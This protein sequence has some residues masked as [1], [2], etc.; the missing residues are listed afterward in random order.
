MFGCSISTD[1]VMHAIE[2]MINTN[3]KLFIWLI[4]FYSNDRR[5]LMVYF[6]ESV[7]LIRALK[8]CL[9]FSVLRC[10]NFKEKSFKL[11]IQNICSEARKLLRRRGGAKGMKLLYI[12][13]FIKDS[14]WMCHN[15]LKQI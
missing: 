8:I 12:T 15:G 9:A 11:E 14:F 5:E 2:T 7:T 6:Q 1:Y 4:I 10:P 13:T 3:I